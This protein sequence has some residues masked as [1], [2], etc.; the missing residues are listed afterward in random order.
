[1]I[2]ATWAAAASNSELKKREVSS[3][4]SFA[5]QQVKIQTYG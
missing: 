1:M 5:P 2:C 4:L 3:S